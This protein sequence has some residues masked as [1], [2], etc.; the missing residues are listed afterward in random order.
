MFSPQTIRDMSDK[1]AREAARKGKRPFVF[2]NEESVNGPPWP[3]PFVGDYVAK[4][5]EPYI[6]DGE[7][8]QL[9]ADSSGFGGD[10]EPALSTRQLT[11]AIKRVMADAA[12][13]GVT[14]GFAL[15]QVGQFQAYIGVFAKKGE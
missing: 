10:N 8:L 7:P 2:Y 1:A 5:W 3:F 9:F 14:V 15:T 13:A 6:E 12:K 11:I 4:G